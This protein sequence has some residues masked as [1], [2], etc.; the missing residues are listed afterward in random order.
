MEFGGDLSRW[1][2]Y[3]IMKRL[4]LTINLHCV[5]SHNSQFTSAPNPLSRN[6]GNSTNLH[7]VTSH[8]SQ[9]TSAPNPLSRNVGNSTN[10]HC[11]TSHN[12]QFTSTPIPLSRYVGNCLPIYTASHPTT[13]SSHQH[14]FPS[15]DTSVNLYQSIL[16]YI[17]R[18]PVHINT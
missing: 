3:L 7:C 14:L 9:F 11:V 2:P 15:P 6:V 5:T 8:Y 10:L 16:C 18:Q 1:G 17:P 13:A 4:Y 12:S